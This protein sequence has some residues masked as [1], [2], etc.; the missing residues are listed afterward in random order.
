MILV[1]SEYIS[2]PLY[3]GLFFLVFTFMILLLTKPSSADKTYTF[4]GILYGLFILTNTIFLFFTEN[5][6]TY[7]FYS[8]VFSLIYIFA[9]YLISKIFIRLFNVNGSEESSMIFLA[10]MYHPPLLLIC[11]FIRWLVH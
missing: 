5:T 4:S 2:K 6:W 1:L 11:M 3:Q 10:I 7:F 9:S 8:S